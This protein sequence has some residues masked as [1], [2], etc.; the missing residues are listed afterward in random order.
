MECKNPHCKG[1]SFVPVIELDNNRLI[2]VKCMDCGAR[3][4]MDEMEVKKSLNRFGWNSVKWY[5]KM[6]GD[7]SNDKT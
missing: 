2:G 6:P 4:T 7:D 5:L 3:Y 1:K